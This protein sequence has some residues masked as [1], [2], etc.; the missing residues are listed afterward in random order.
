MTE[1]QRVAALAA[2]VAAGHPYLPQVAGVTPRVSVAAAP[3]SSSAA[4]P[5]ADAAWPP[6]GSTPSTSGKRKASGDSS[7]G[8]LVSCGGGTVVAR[9]GADQLAK[10]GQGQPSLRPSERLEAC[11]SSMMRSAELNHPSREEQIMQKQQ[12]LEELQRVERELQEKAHAQIVL[13]A[14][15]HQHLAVAASTEDVVEELNLRNAALS[16]SSVAVPPSTGAAAEITALPSSSLPSSSTATP[17]T[18]L[19][20]AAKRHLDKVKASSGK[21]QLPPASGAAV[22]VPTTK[23]ASTSMVCP[24]GVGGSCSGASLLGSFGA[25]SPQAEGLMVA[26]PA[27]TLHEALGEIVTGPTAAG[28]QC[29]GGGS[30]AQVSITA[31]QAV[32]VC[33]DHHHHPHHHHH[34]HHGGST[35]PAASSLAQQPPSLAFHP[36][37]F[38]IHAQ[39]DLNWQTESNHDTALTLACA[40][41]HEDLVSLLLNRGAHLEHRDKKGFTPLMLAA[42]A[43]HAGVVDILLSHG[44]DLEAQSERTKDTALSLACSGGRYEVVEI[45][46]ARGANKEHRNVSDYTPLSLAASGGYVNI[47]KL[48]LQHGAE[49]NSRTGSKLGISPLMLAAMNGHVAAVRLLLDNGSDINAQIETN[50]NTALTLACFQGRQEVVALLVDR[51]A[52]VEHRAKTGLTPLMEAASGGYVEVGRVL[53]DKGADVNAPPVPSSRDTA[54]TIAADK[55]HYAFVELLIKRGAAIDV[56]N[57]KGSSPLWLACNGGYLDVVQLLVAA[58]AD[59]DSMDNRRVSCLMAA[60]RRGHVKAAKWLVK[61]VAQF[62]SD[63][64]MA[65]FMATLGPD[66]RDLLRKCHQ[67]TEVIHAAKERQ[68]AE[69][70][71]CASSLLEELD[72]ERSRE[73]N[74]RAA[75]ARRRE[76]KRRKK[77]E[78]QEQMRLAKLEA[79]GGDKGASAGANNGKD[80]DKD[81]KSEGDKPPTSSQSEEDDDD[82][83]EEED[84]DSSRTL[85]PSSGSSRSSRLAELDERLPNPGG[86][87]GNH[88][89]TITTGS[90]D[91]GSG[92]PNAPGRPKANGASSS[93]T[94]CKVRLKEDDIPPFASHESS[95]SPSSSPPKAP[96]SAPAESSSKNSRKKKQQVAACSTAERTAEPASTRLNHTM[97]PSPVAST[98][99]GNSGSKLGKVALASQAVLQQTASVVTRIPLAMTQPSAVHRQTA[100]VAKRGGEVM[101]NGL[102]DGEDFSTVVKGTKHR[103]QGQAHH[104][105]TDASSKTSTLGD[106][107]LDVIDSCGGPR[108]PGSGAG[109]PSPGVASSPKKSSSTVLSTSSSTSMTTSSATAGA[110]IG[111]SKSHHRGEE[112]WK[113]VV[114]R[115]K[116][117]T[118]PSTAISRVIGRCGCNINAIREASGAHIEVE[119]HK[120]QGERTILIRGSA[121]ATKQAQLLIQGLVQ[122][123][124]RDLS[125]IMAQHGVVAPSSAKVVASS[126]DHRT[127][128]ISSSSATTNHT[129]CSSVLVSGS[130]STNKLTRQ[131]SSAKVV[132]VKAASAPVPSLPPFGQTRPAPRPGIPTHSGGSSGN[133]VSVT[134]SSA[135]PFA[136]GSAGWGSLASSS[137]ALTKPTATAA[138]PVTSASAV[139]TTAPAVSTSSAAINGTTMT[140]ASYTQAV[141]SPAKSSSRAASADPRPSSSPSSGGGSPS[142]TLGNTGSMAV[143]STASTT[144]NTTMA[145]SVSASMSSISTAP[146]ISIPQTFSPFNNVFSK[147]TQPSVWGQRE[148]SKPNFASVAASGVCGVP[149]SSGGSVGS[150]SASSEPLVDAAKAPGY[151][152]N[153]HVSPPNF[154]PIGSGPRSAPCTPPIGGGAP[155]SPPSQ[156]QPAPQPQ[157]QEFYEN[158][159]APAAVPQ[160]VQATP[161]PSSS[162][163]VFGPPHYAATAPE[164]APPPQQQQQPPPPQQPTIQSTL[165]PNAP[166]FSSRT[167]PPVML[168]APFPQVGTGHHH[169]HHH[170]AATPSHHGMR[171]P[172]AP[173]QEYLHPVQSGS[174]LGHHHHHHHQGAAAGTLGHPGV[175]PMQMMS[176]LQQQY[177]GLVAPVGQMPKGAD[178]APLG[179]RLT[180]EG[181]PSAVSPQGGLSPGGGLDDRKL[182]RPIGTERAQKKG[183]HT[184]YPGI[185][186]YSNSAAGVGNSGG[187][188][189]LTPDLSAMQAWVQYQH[190]A[191]PQGDGL[192]PLLQHNRFAAAAEAASEQQALEQQSY[193]HQ[194]QQPALNAGG[195]GNCPPF[196]NGFPSGTAGAM[197]GGAAQL[198][199]SRVATEAPHQPQEA[200]PWSPHKLMGS[201]PGDSLHHHAGHHPHH[202]QQQPPHHAHVATAKLPWQNWTHHQT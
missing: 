21:Q 120:G 110:A 183:V 43:G 79:E 175:F 153:L 92:Q 15:H 197:L 189:S 201:A 167:A 149:S 186:S 151:R 157:A 16:S 54:L 76:R 108:S 32:T 131:G 145:P 73:E 60:F 25:A 133:S 196:L 125:D 41:G 162:R 93:S 71:K 100:V 48:L 63:Q 193:H 163:L 80:S 11:I 77:K 134:S 70:N 101:V 174:H 14:Q 121:E 31:Q 184:T 115:S 51:K 129:G 158:A 27:R 114:R 85:V 24:P 195:L 35:H 185:W 22:T 10:T 155:P 64:E 106:L 8:P 190:A 173:V 57:K 141:I 39:V 116:K 81:S 62:P 177:S 105:V 150:V 37:A 90:S 98:K 29:G 200:T 198:F 147:E 95:S 142:P 88:M 36:A 99:G 42:T 137:S 7:S 74:R 172:F 179:V 87:S 68:A 143:S 12:I 28:T 154:G 160:P 107:A 20:A 72:L 103:G 23:D 40:G 166:D 182:P 38:P 69:A 128:T 112:G 164:L 180:D 178:R 187:G 17:S 188:S 161:Q 126:L 159:S 117:V 3:S 65:R 56:K 191:G 146:A 123:P 53:L 104:V 55:G 118:V 33:P 94:P 67:C 168:A 113:E 66:S 6:S 58:Q 192:S 176:H 49:I 34:H 170:P 5:S 171:V 181:S 52:N 140:S 78:K 1:E 152:G 127:T 148:A 97:S 89:A 135:P 83:E 2:A 4:V 46:L 9:A 111:T 13:S 122:E 102:A 30:G 26:A 138:T 169:Q 139:V 119:K 61:Q 84:D 75:A 44:A 50:K 194:P 156:P 96:P 59:I 165:N 18:L 202:P 130:S 124:D 47:I 91:R 199:S 45:L 86:G 136:S 19:P 132:G 144:S 82:D 109:R